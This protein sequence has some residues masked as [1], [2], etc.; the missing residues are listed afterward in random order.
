MESFLF[1]VN[2]VAPLVLTVAVGY[3]LKRIGVIT[4]AFASQANKLVFKALLPI[5]L[6]LNIYNINTSVGINPS[7][8]IFTV[9]AVL[10]FFLLGLIT[11]PLVTKKRDRKAP[12]IQAI[13]RSNYALIGVPLAA[14]IN[15]ENG[16]AV[17]SVVVIFTIPLFNILAVLLFSIFSVSKKPSIK[18]ALL[19][20]VKNPLIIGVAAGGVFLL[21]KTALK[22]VGINTTLEDI[23]LIYKT[24]SYLSSAATPLALISLGAQFEFSALGDFRKEIIFG[25]AARTALVPAAALLIAHNMNIFT[26][27]EIA[28]FIGVFATPVAVS[29]VPM[30]QELGGDS[31]LAGQLVVFT[32]IASA[33]SIFILTFIFKAIGVFS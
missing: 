5:M 32:T 27:A 14:A 10:L 33:F 4:S 8:I 30:A 13:F 9:T 24:L 7:Y 18:N 2:A 1:A 23:P 20:I 28:C 11:V 21:A 16:A 15:P 12:L 26:P 17:A 31:R 3:F 25:T 29:T 19:D 6:F 22:S